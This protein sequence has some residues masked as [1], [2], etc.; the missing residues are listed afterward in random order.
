MKVKVGQQYKF[1][2]EQEHI[3]KHGIIEIASVY[4][5]IS[6]CYRAHIIKGSKE[7]MS[8]QKIIRLRIMF[9]EGNFGFL[10]HQIE[11]E[12]ILINND[13]DE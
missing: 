9:P 1:I 5:N 13:W 8:T 2:K 6:Y 3:H 12:A 4:N 11:R 10:K 7:I